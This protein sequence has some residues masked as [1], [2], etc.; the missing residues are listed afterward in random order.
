[1]K[2]QKYYFLVSFFLCTHCHIYAPSWDSF[3]PWCSDNQRHEFQFPNALS[4][5]KCSVLCW[6]KSNFQERRGCWHIGPFKN[7]DEYRSGPDQIRCHSLIVLKNIQHS[8]FLFSL[9]YFSWWTAC[10]TSVSYIW[11]VSMSPGPSVE[12]TLAPVE[13]GEGTCLSSSS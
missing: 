2:K 1:M 13:L 7:G 5:P 10:Y 12:G 8:F 3:L 11:I 9:S 6:T 4:T